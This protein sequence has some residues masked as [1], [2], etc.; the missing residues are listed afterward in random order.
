MFEWYAQT[1]WSIQVDLYASYDIILYH[2]HIKWHLLVLHCFLGMFVSLNTTA[3]LEVFDGYTRWVL[4]SAKVGSG[5]VDVDPLEKKRWLIGGQRSVYACDVSICLIYID[6]RSILFI[7]GFVGDVYPFKVFVKSTKSMWG[8]C[9]VRRLRDLGLNPCH[10]W[11]S[12]WIPQ[13]GILTHHDDQ[14]DQW[15]WTLPRTIPCFSYVS[16]FTPFQCT[17]SIHTCIF[18][19]I[20]RRIFAPGQ[21]LWET[22][23]FAYFFWHKVCIY[24]YIEDWNHVSIPSKCILN[25]FPT[26]PLKKG[27]LK[28]GLQ[29]ELEW[30][31]SRS[32]SPCGSIQ[33][34]CKTHRG[35][36]HFRWRL[37][38]IYI[39][40][41]YIHINWIYPPPR[42]PVPNEGLQ[43]FPTKYDDFRLVVTVG[44][45]RSNIQNWYVNWQWGLTFWWD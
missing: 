11:S 9:N 40:T 1:Y 35:F 24:I 2:P 39:Y 33:V 31:T 18:V 42:I 41:H 16:S 21:L 32:T 4:P 37:I 17:I 43:G 30:S 12:S 22:I 44:G 6:I 34:P 38:F 27:I 28:P 13:I 7:E 45:R 20:F 14:C 25:T 10:V 29:R 36:Y 19:F 23:C 8:E 5:L 3:C 26:E 15:W